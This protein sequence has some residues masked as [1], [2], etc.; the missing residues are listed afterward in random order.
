MILKQDL[1]TTVK[2]AI[3]NSKVFQNAVVT[4]KN[5][6]EYDF[7]KMYVSQLNNEGANY[8]NI[9]ATQDLDLMYE[10]LVAK[11]I[12]LYEGSVQRNIEDELK[13]CRKPQ[14]QANQAV[15][16]KNTLKID[17]NNF[18]S[19]FEEVNFPNGLTVLY[20]IRHMDKIGSTV[21]VDKADYDKYE[22]GDTTEDERKEI[23]S[24][25]MDNV[26]EA[27]K[28]DYENVEKTIESY[29]VEIAILWSRK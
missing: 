7:T 28:E 10:V 17:I 4:R 6:K 1:N 13:C 11:I 22:A 15:K 3:R 23:I 20:Q 19:C 27:E 21:E 18:Y 5:L 16:G 8:L 24:N 9:P 29:F 25:F 12:P 14:Q 26:I 2:R